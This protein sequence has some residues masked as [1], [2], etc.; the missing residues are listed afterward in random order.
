MLAFAEELRS[1]GAGLRVLSLSGGDADSATPV[2]SV[3]FTIMVALPQMEHEIKREH[4]TGSIS[5]RSGSGKD[6][7][8]PP[9][10]NT[11]SQIRNTIRLV[12]GDEA[13]VQVARGLGMSGATFYRRARALTE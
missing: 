2:V 3:L 1:G 6:L 7:G 4:I 10:W 11:D 8:G 5:K 9:C 12:E 13:V